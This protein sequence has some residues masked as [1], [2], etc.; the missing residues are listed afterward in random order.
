[1]LFFS[2]FFRIA[3]GNICRGWIKKACFAK[4]LLHFLSKL[5]PPDL[6]ELWRDFNKRICKL[7]RVGLSS[8]NGKKNESYRNKRSKIGL[9]GMLVVLFLAWLGSGI[10]IV[11]EG[12]VGVISRF[13]KYVYTTNPGIQ[14]SFP[15]PIESYEIVNMTQV[16][17][18][19]IGRRSVSQ[20]TNL[21]DASMLTADENIIDVRFAVQYRIKNAADFLFN[22]VDAEA[23]VA[24]AAETAIREIV[25]K[26]K[27]DT[28][29]YEGRE[30]V[31]VDLTQLIQRIL[32]TYKTGIAVSNVAVHSV[33]PPSQVQVAFDDVV[34]ATQDVESKIHD[35]YAYANKIVPLAEGMAT[36]MIEEAK[37]YRERRLAEANGDASR[38]SA[39]VSEYRKSPNVTRERLY[40]ETMQDIYSQSM[41]VLISNKYGSNVVCLPL[42][43]FFSK[44]QNRSKISEKSEIS[45][46]SLNE[47]KFKA[48]SKNLVINQE[49]RVNK[50]VVGLSANKRYD[51]VTDLLG[52]R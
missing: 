21:N 34:K 17:S 2:N 33:Q 39:I 52:K 27:M 29:L 24:Q 49:D 23:N 19:E 50:K 18:V 30:Q 26:S 28:V 45:T 48:K 14:W 16:R 11:H 20:Q 13:G 43:N 41:K 4:V 8:N 46:D 22:N 15:S 9:M 37:G 12:Q 42:D 3:S 6:D 40:I 51:V 47:K 44:K 36:R 31:A 35:A 7:F 38:F 5:S 32:D 25:G 1:M 10:Y